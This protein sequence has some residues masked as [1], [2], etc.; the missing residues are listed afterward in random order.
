[1]RN[2]DDKGEKTMKEWKNKDVIAGLIVIIILG[3][4]ALFLLI[5]RE[6]RQFP[7]KET[8]ILYEN[9]EEV[10]SEESPEEIQ[11]EFIVEEPEEEDV[12]EE[13]TQE[14]SIEEENQNVQD[15]VEIP[16]VTNK[17]PGYAVAKRS[18]QKK[19]YAVLGKE[20]YVPATLTER[21]K[22]DGQLKELYDY[23]ESYKLNAVGDLIRLE[24]FQ[25]IS[26]ELAGTNKF[27]YYGSVDRLGRPSG[28]GLA[29]Y[30]DNTYYYG[31]WK[32]GL[33][34]GNGMWLEVAIYT[35]ENKKEN[36]GV[37]E[38]SYN[39]QW[40]KDF[41]NG[42]GQEHFTYDYEILEEDVVKNYNAIANV[43]GNFKNGYYHGE[44]YIMTTDEEGNTLDWVGNCQN[45]VWDII[46]E[47]KTTDAVWENYDDTKE[48][49]YNYL[50][51][52]ENK[53]WGIIGLKK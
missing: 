24:R 35:E 36:L 16:L 25:E 14:E 27:Y 32:D 26:E 20:T 17:K 6:I 33:R 50:F 4:I 45:G 46:M 1:M 7:E 37:V 49:R 21:K 10:V 11:E 15:S 9:Q 23:W 41:P 34:H 19:L 47:G 53:N 5:K 30:E 31:E 8:E 39:G 22:E 29:V 12:I 3:L 18:E 2:M 38:H 42:E 40:S 52:T 13:E 51:P 28:Q 44:M 43:I 48:E